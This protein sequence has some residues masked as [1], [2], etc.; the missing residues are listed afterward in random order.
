VGPLRELLTVDQGAG[1]A[2]LVLAVVWIVALAAL[3]FRKD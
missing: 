1:A 2:V 3:A